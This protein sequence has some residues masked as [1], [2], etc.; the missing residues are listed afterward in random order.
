LSASGAQN[1]KQRELANS[2]P[3]NG[4]PYS[5]KAASAVVQSYFEKLS[6]VRRR[7]AAGEE[8]GFTLIELLIVIVVLGILAATVIFALSG[9]TGSSAQAA[10]NSDAKSVEVAVVAFENASTNTN[11]AAPAA[12]SGTSTD[13]PL[14]PKYLQAWP[15]NSGYV[16]TTDASGNVYVN[17]PGGTTQST[18]TNYNSSV[19][20]CDAS[21][22]S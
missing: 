2:D 17:P 11:N 18:A 1:L 16:I 8:F 4:I 3:N 10:C 14:V 20:P 9:V 6:E 21:N 12:I 15:T 7:R 13:T 5:R 22:I 19:N